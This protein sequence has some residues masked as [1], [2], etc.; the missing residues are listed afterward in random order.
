MCLYC[1]GVKVTVDTHKLVAEAF[2]PNPDNLPEINHKNG[3]HEDPDVSNLE[4]VTS[5]ENREH[6][7]DMGLRGS[8]KIEN[9]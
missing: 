6:S 2:I 5:E 8:K 7:K 3:N 9:L 1:D 4:W